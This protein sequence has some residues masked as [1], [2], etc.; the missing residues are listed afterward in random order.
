MGLRYVLRKLPTSCPDLRHRTRTRFAPS[1]TGPLH[2]G[3]LRTALVNFLLARRNGGDF[4][5][6]IE[7]T[8]QIH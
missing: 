2:I 3:G 6:R 8:D 7:D 4:I 1:P 5:L